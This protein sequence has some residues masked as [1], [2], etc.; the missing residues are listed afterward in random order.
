MAGR[1]TQQGHYTRNRQQ[2]NAHCTTRHDPRTCPGRC[3]RQL[4]ATPLSNQQHAGGNRQESDAEEFDW[5]IG[6]VDADAK[7]QQRIDDHRQPGPRPGESRALGLKT[8]IPHTLYWRSKTIAAA[9]D[10]ARMQIDKTGKSLEYGSEHECLIAI[11]LA[12]HR[13]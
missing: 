4:A 12:L 10:S 9:A 2:N 8:R 7:H 13:W 5:P 11:S 1:S 3:L 6:R